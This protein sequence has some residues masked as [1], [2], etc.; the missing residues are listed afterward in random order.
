MRPKGEILP[1]TK[2]GLFDHL[3]KEAKTDEWA[4][5]RKEITPY[6]VAHG[7]YNVCEAKLPVCIGTALELQFAH[8]KKR[9]DWA[10]D[11]RARQED[12]REVIRACTA[13]HEALEHL[14]EK[15]G[16]TGRERMRDAIRAIIAGRGFNVYSKRSAQA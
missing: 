12:A 13:C 11:G 4:R 8:S 3:K 5:V 6:F 16:R 7:I 10:T 1:K 14:P 15:D 2:K 9:V